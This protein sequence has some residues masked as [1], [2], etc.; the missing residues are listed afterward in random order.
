[1]KYVIRTGFMIGA[2]LIWA[3]PAS[4][5]TPA[6]LESLEPTSAFSEVKASSGVVFVDL[7]AHW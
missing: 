3:L 6:A 1:M 2:L 5:T 4:A 7:Y